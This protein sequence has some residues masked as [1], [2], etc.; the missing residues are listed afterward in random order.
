MTFTQ[1]VETIREQG[2]NDIEHIVADYV[3]LKRSGSGMK[4]LCPFHDEKTPSFN[5]SAAKRYFKCFGCGAGGDVIDFIENME[6]LEFHEVIYKLADRYNITID[7]NSRQSSR[8]KIHSDEEILPGIRAERTEIRKRGIV[9]INFKGNTGQF[10]PSMPEVTVSP[11]LS[12][13]QAAV[14]RKYTGTCCFIT[15]GIDWPPVKDSIKAAIQNNLT[16]NILYPGLSCIYEKEWIDYIL[17]E[18]GGRISRREVIELLAAIPDNLTRSIYT[19]H[20][21]ENLNT[22]NN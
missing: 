18:V 11:P 15:G 3:K 20:F 22:N 5:V 2:G 1:A 13:N 7:K 10:R 21:S 6:G 14:I 19:T 12:N 9:A 8:E 16:V 17:P 4:G